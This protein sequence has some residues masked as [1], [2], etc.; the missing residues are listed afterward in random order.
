MLSRRAQVSQV[1]RAAL[2]LHKT[3]LDAVRAGFEKLHGPVRDSGALLGLVMSDPLFAWLRPLSGLIA[4]LDALVDETDVPLDEARLAQL[5][6]T[7]ERWTSQSAGNDDFAAN[8][9][10]YL[11]SDPEVVM[12][13]AV[14]RDRL[15]ALPQ[16]PPP[17]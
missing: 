8:Y 3:L 7:L 12:A 6:A 10:V 5:R 17:G 15:V 4:E 9:R 14:L 13:H 11:Q 16:P 2:V 1:A